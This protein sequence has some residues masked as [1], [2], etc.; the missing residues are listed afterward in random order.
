MRARAR[1][2]WGGKEFCW[3]RPSPKATAAIADAVVELRKAKA[4]E[5]AN[6]KHI[7]T[8][9]GEIAGFMADADTLV[10]GHTRL[11]TY[12]TVERKGFSVAPSSSRQFRLVG[13]KE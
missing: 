10:H 9:Q 1:A 13:D 7:E 5:K 11:L 6:K 12:K 2:C 3:A 8:L 4:D